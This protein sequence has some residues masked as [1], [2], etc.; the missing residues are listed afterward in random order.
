MMP[1]LG[2]QYLMPCQLQEFSMLKTTLFA[3]ALTLTAVSAAQATVVFSDDFNGEAQ[4]LGNGP[5][6]GVPLD[7]WTVTE[8]TVDVIGTGRFDFYPGNGNYLDMNGSTGE[9]G[10]IETNRVFG[11]GT[12][13]LTFDYGLN[14]GGAA[15]EVLSFGIGSTLVDTLAISNIAS[16]LTSYVITFTTTTGGSLFFADTGD[17]DGDRGGPVIDNISLA[18]VPLPAAGLLLLGALGGLAALRRRKAGVA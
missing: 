11:A 14:L 15:T 4:E 8:G 17:T 6:P 18:A 16:T 2:H 13:T 9:A 7:Q 5:G 10:R 12:Y 3:S 1:N